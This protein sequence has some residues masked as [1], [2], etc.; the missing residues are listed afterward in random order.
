M[1]FEG[2]SQYVATDD[3]MVAV[4]ASITL[5]RPLLVK[6]APDPLMVGLR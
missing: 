1:R 4:N 5:Q 3:L 2:T 6:R